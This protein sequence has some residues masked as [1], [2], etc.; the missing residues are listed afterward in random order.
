MHEDSQ[1]GGTIKGIR[2][3]LDTADPQKLLPFENGVT[4]EGLMPIVADAYGHLCLGREYVRTVPEEEFD[5]RKAILVPLLL[6]V[7]TLRYLAENLD[8]LLEGADVKISRQT[9]VEIL[10]L[11]DEVAGKNLEV[12]RAWDELSGPLLDLD[13]ASRVRA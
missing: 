13:G 7:A 11:A 6:A 1:S 9:V 5:I 12:Q 10:M 4:H 8:G 3:I 2:I